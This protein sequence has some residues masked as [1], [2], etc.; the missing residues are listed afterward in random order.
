MRMYDMIYDKRQ[1]KAHSDEDIREMLAAYVKGEIPDYQMSA[2]LM[3]VCFQGMTDGELS[4]LTHAMAHSGDTVDLSRFGDTT[5]D[6]HSTGGVGDK[7]SMVV[8]PMVAACGLTVAKMSGRGLGHTGGTVDKLESIPG[9][10]TT[11][12]AEHFMHQAQKVGMALIGQSGNLTPADKML[13]ALRD[14]TATVDCIPLI[15][16]SIMSKKLAAGAKSIVLDVKMGSG[17]FLR[18]IEDATALAEKMTEIGKRCGR[19]MA[20]VI[21]DMDVPLGSLVGN[22]LEVQEAIEALHGRGPADLRELCLVLATE[23]VS[24]GLGMDKNEARVKVTEVLD[25]GKALAKC[26]EWVEAQ[27]GDSSY[28][29]H[30]EKFPAPA[31]TYSVLAEQDGYITAMDTTAIGRAAQILGAGRAKKED[32]IDLTAGIRVLQKT[33]AYVKKGDVLAIL[34]TG[35]PQTVADAEICY[36]EALSFGTTPP[37]ERPLVYKIV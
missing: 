1:G 27:G 6:K 10:Q 8:A 7:T 35:R 15:A 16:S 19:R 23:M 25:S 31:V 29:M 18:T 2:W 28:I 11:L 24:L 14:V 21:S 20:A 17:A 12:S 22:I 32:V 33:G 37:A 34:Q 36:R 30:P 26:C 9:Y 13:Y 5:V 3:A 4:T